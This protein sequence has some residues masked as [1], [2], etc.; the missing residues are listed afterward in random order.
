VRLPQTS[1]GR[2]TLWTLAATLPLGFAAFFLAKRWQPVDDFEAWWRQR[3]HVRSNGHHVALPRDRA[4]RD[5][6]FV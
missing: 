1:V 4:R 6:L 2:W 5:D 3:E